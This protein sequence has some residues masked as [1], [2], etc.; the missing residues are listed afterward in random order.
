MKL[1]KMLSSILAGAVF[2]T[3]F[4]LFGETKIVK[5]AS[6]ASIPNTSRQIKNYDK[7][8]MS[9]TGFASV[10]NSVSDRSKYVGTSYYRKVGSEREF[11]NAVLEA[12]SGKVKVIE[13][14]KDLNLGWKELNLDSG[15]KS[16]YS[17]LSEYEKPTNG[18]TNPTLAQA[19]VS[20]L[21]IS[22]TNGLTIFSTSGKT[23]RHTEFKL[24]S[25]AN[26]IAIRNLKFDDMWQFDDSGKHKEVGWTFIKVNGANNVWIDHCKFTNA[27]DGNVDIENG[28][29][30]LTFSWCEFGAETTE[31]PS[32]DSAIYKSI[33]YMEQ[34]YNSGQL[35]SNSVYYKMRKGGATKNQIMAFEAYHSKCSLVGSGDKDFTNYVDSNGKDY[36]D[37][38]QRLRLTLAYCK[39][40]NVGQRV[41]MI[42]QGVGHMFNCVVDDTG[43][44]DIL[45]KVSAIKNL[46]IDNLARCINA[47][48]GASIGAD[49]CVFNGVNEPIVGTERQGDDVA[50]MNKPW[51]TLFAN[52]YNNALIVNSKVT[53]DYGTYT[54]SSWDNN[55][56]NLF[57]KGYTWN[58]KS[59]L[60]KW[61]W[62]SS[63]NGV[64]NMK[65]SVTPTSPFTFTYNYNEKLP[66]SYNVVPLDNVE[67]TVKFYSGVGK[68]NMD[69]SEWLKTN[70]AGSQTTN[71]SQTPETN[72]GVGGYYRIKNV[73]SSKYLS[74]PNNDS[75]AKVVQTS[76]TGDNTIW[77]VV[78]GSESGYIK[79]AAQVGDGRKVLDVT[80][81]SS[82][83]SA[84]IQ[85]WGNGSSSNQDF[86]LKNLGAGK[87]GILSRVSGDVRCLDVSGYSSNEG[88]SVIQYD[89]KGSLNQQW[90]FERVNYTHPIVDGGVY[91]IKNYNSNLYMDVLDG[92]DA[93]GTNVRQWNGNGADAQRFK[94]V[95]TGDGYYKLVSQAGGKKRVIDVNGNSASNGANISLYDD[96]GTD[97]Q[98]FKLIDNGN[99]V[100]QIATKIS[101]NKSMVEIINA[102]KKAGANIQQW[103]SNNNN[104]QKWVFEIIR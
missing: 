4:S 93:N 40:N 1:K 62:S 63:I 8:F 24:Q 13:I 29:S 96:R 59:T 6:I 55:G 11:L 33:N 47:R 92:K 64:N 34:K 46:N 30:G 18:Y 97:N 76:S 65:K 28:S 20:K 91:Y 57:T 69:A 7:S 51:D 98:K 94:V 72:V 90:V 85:I 60:G 50:N 89:Y 53:N 23:I 81:G 44:M 22:N 100:F 17:F 25:S 35:D 31:N 15:E 80:G 84:Q 73:N 21:N 87:F 32:S 27:A 83:N 82:S 77:Q 58:N 74:V 45:K 42:R 3:S 68:V 49:T 19:G 39:Y 70:Y 75:G 88:A 102:D 5:A 86:K 10:N 101:N 12:Q 37:G 78:G 36:K 54:G 56:S 99:G 43:H 61:A 103:S 79:L 67:S 38:N 104:C 9:L 52:A 71:P 14:T 95:S 66:Y 41:P 16:K 26:D 2:I 48:N